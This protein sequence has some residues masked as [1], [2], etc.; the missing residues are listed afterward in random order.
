MK[1]TTVLSLLA[2]GAS[3]APVDGTEH[4]LSAR[5][6]CNNSGGTA[7]CCDGL[8]GCLLSLFGDECGHDTYCCDIGNSAVRTVAPSSTGTG[9]LSEASMLTLGK[10]NGAIVFNNCNKLL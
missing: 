6:L 3:A 9:D 5:E 7:I 8:L 4:E 1:Y 2:L 10:G